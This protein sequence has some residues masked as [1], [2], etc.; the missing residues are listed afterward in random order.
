MKYIWKEKQVR[1]T[2]SRQRKTICENIIQLS[3][4]KRRKERQDTQGTHG[5]NQSIAHLQF[6][7]CCCPKTSHGS[8]KSV[9]LLIISI[10]ISNSILNYPIKDRYKHP[11]CIFIQ[12]ESKSSKFYYCWW[13]A[14]N[15]SY[16][17]GDNPDKTQTLLFL[18]ALIIFLRK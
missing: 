7:G 2:P 8:L 10:S 18:L 12:F 11:N 1:K 13:L 14:V 9:A 4:S 16:K 6:G 17:K 5:T 15:I 3:P